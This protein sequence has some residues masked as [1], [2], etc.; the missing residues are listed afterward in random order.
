MMKETIKNNLKNLVFIT[1]KNDAESLR[2]IEILKRQKVK[3]LVTEQTWGAS[4]DEIEAEIKEE[5]KALQNS[6]RIFGVELKGAPLYN[7]ANIDHHWHD[8]DNRSNDKSSLEQVAELIGYELTLEDMFISSNDKGYIPAMYSLG[9]SLD[10]SQEEIEK[11]VSRVRYLD[12]SAQ[13]ITPEQEAI[14]EEAIA[15]KEIMNEHSYLVRMNH[16]KTSPVCDRLYGTYKNLLIVSEDGEVNFFGAKE[17]INKLQDLVPGSWCGGDIQ[18]D[19]GFWGGYPA[20]PEAII[21][22][23]KAML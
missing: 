22:L 21:S 6:H 16:S 2:I 12:R 13:G 5:L 7:G 8:G 9:E 10:M 19:N 20:V 18:N 15:K 1:P 3:V 14:A 4:W 11:M 23:V 17:I